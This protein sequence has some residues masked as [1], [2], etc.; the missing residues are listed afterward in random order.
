[1]NGDWL[2]GLLSGIRLAGIW[3]RNQVRDAR[4]AGTG[5]KMLSGEADTGKRGPRFL[6][7]QYAKRGIGQKL[8][9]NRSGFA[10]SGRL[11]DLRR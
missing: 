11:A 1:M 10:L 4:R 7:Q 2:T 6:G 5:R 9:D 8:N 3:L